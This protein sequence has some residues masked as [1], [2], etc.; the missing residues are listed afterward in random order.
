M[1]RATPLLAAR[2]A[3]RRFGHRDALE[4]VEL[5]IWDGEAVALVDVARVA[6]ELTGASQDLIEEVEPPAGRVMTRIATERIRALG[7]RAEVALDDGMRMLL[8]QIRAGAPA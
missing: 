4:P 7:W 8:D 6:C 3:G 5:E 1:T 2:G